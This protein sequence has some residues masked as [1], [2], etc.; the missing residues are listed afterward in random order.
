MLFFAACYASTGSKSLTTS[1]FMMWSI[2]FATC[3]WIV[4]S[5][6]RWLVAGIYFLAM[7]P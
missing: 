1:R 7:S 2:Y 4:V 5:A 3:A 6:L